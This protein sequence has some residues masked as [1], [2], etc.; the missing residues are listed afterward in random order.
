MSAFSIK[1]A[2]II[3]LANKIGVTTANIEETDIEPNR[4]AVGKVFKSLED[5]QNFEIEY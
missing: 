4:D 2:V 1:D 5:Y 3:C